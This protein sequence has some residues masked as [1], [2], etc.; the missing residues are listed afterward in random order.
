MLFEALNATPVKAR[1]QTL[2]LE[3]L[4]STPAQ[5]AV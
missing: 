3:A 2:A 5:M 1:F 4:P